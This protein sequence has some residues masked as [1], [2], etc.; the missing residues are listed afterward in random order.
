MAACDRLDECVLPSLERDDVVTSPYNAALSLPCILRCADVVLPFD[1]QALVDICDAFHRSQPTVQ[2][3]SQPPVQQSTSPPQPPASVIGGG[4][5]EL[6]V[7]CAS[8]LTGLTAGMRFPGELNVD[9]SDLVMNLC[10][11]T[12]TNLL[13]PALAP[14]Q[15]ALQFHYDSQQPHSHSVERATSRTAAPGSGR[16]EAHSS[17]RVNG[18]LAASSTADPLSTHYFHTLN[19]AQSLC[20]VQSTARNSAPVFGSSIRTARVRGDLD[21]IRNGRTAGQQEEAMFH[22]AMQQSHQLLQVSRH[23]T[24]P[25]PPCAVWLV[26]IDFVL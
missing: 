3:A 6:N 19:A 20:S 8:V 16:V 21:G 26:L 13:V 15:P 22:S 4:F 17:G 23:C 11:F 12:D 10:P 24:S 1:N 14:L 18:R 5:R 25:A 2:S 9:L 7:L